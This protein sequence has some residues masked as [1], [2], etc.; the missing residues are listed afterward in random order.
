MSTS[1]DHLVEEYR[2]GDKTQAE[3][4]RER[5][6]NVNTLRYHLYKKNKRRKSSNATPFISFSPSA[7]EQKHPVTI[8]RGQFTLH[9]L[10]EIL[11]GGT[12]PC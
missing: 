9:E 1:G 6:I 5:Q 8:I 12:Q 3:F 10:F 11:S 7:M 4:C 2:N